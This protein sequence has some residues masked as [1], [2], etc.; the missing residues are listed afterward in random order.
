[1]NQNRTFYTT[2]PYNCW[3]INCGLQ[4]TVFDDNTIEITGNPHHDFSRGRLCV[5]GQ[6]CLEIVDNR[7]RLT[8]PLKRA[9]RNGQFQRISWDNALDEI[10]EKIVSNNRN[11]HREATALYHSHGNIVQRVNW[12][13]L[14]PRFANLAGITLWDGNF[15]CWYDVG[16]AQQLTGY[17]GLHDPAL[18]CENTS[19]LINWAQDPCASQANMVPYILKVRENNG[20]VVTIDPRVTQTAALS[21][22]HIRPRL[23]TDVWLANAIAHILI[24]NDTYDA[25]YVNE[26]CHGFES[27]KEHIVNYSPVEASRICEIPINEIERLAE[28]FAE[29]KPLSI[30]LTRGALGKHSNGIQMVRSILCLIPLSG[31]LGIKGG[32]A[33]W[34]EAID[35][36]MDLCCEERRPDAP[37]PLNNFAAID[38]AL[39]QGHV[40]TL[41]VVGGNPLSQWPNLSRLRRQCDNL[42]LVVVYDLFMNHTAREAGDIILPA[43]SWLEELGLRTSSRN[44]Y[45]MDKVLEPLAQCREAS[46]WMNDLSKRLGIE[47]YFPWNSKEEC[48]NACLLS[49]AC[50]GVTVEE[51]RNHPEGIEADVPQAPYA[52]NVFDSPTKKFELYS[53]EALELSLSPLPTHEPSIEGITDTPELA[54]RY[55]L[56]LISSRRNTHFHS[57]HNSH[58]V[59]DT[60][61]RL[62][63]E[64]I[65]CMHPKDAFDRG[66]D[67]GCRV[68]LFNK[69]G[70]GR[71]KVE[72]T[73]E[74]PPK[75]V[76]MND[77]WPELN[78]V[79]ASYTPCPIKITEKFG[80]GGQP[81]YQNVL[82][83]VRGEK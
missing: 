61:H 70:S 27:Y 53:K 38:D 64:P 22:I 47:D 31:N 81:A 79:T 14:T 10:A 5:K 18:T 63:P 15:P 45:L 73:T 3:P 42:D 58:N 68:V 46:S 74:V 60:L 25:D 34:G 52:E 50:R 33:I 78:E 8:T 44:M 37:Y 40:N 29:S 21:D 62:E 11:G 19:A 49:K 30:N 77:C 65:L 75:H 39:G 36:N 71:V 32:G 83:E 4:V 35:W 9:S 7:K 26:H 24:Q 51:L 67:D 41:L 54:Q 56:Q 59:I 12:R 48:L 1:M 16:V 76:S 28:I 72:I 80:V 20:I 57:F 66:L 13:I 43:T 23:G 6:S 82:V 55:P 17:W 2:C 69:R